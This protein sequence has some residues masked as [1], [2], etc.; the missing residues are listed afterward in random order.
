MVLRLASDDVRELQ[1]ALSAVYSH[2][3]RQLNGVDGYFDRKAGLELC[4][5]KWRLEALLHQ[6]DHAEAPPPVLELVTASLSESL[7]TEAA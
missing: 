6:L 4:Q 7:Q 5:R 2:T 1:R 3:L